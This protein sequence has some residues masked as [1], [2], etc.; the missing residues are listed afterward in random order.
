MIYGYARVSTIEQSTDVQ[1][2]ALQAAGCAEIIEE[3]GSGADRRRPRLAALLAKIQA[4]DIIVVWKIDRLARSVAHLS[5]IIELL[6]ERGAH[7]RS[8]TDPIDTSSPQGTFVTQL[9]GAVAEL[10]RSLIKERV[11]SGLAHARKQGRTGGNP[12]L[13]ARDPAALKELQVKANRR[14][15]AKY[16]ANTEDWIHIV[17]E[18]RPAKPWEVV[19][20]TVNANLVAGKEKWTLGRLKRAVAHMAKDNL[21]DKVLLTPAPPNKDDRL[22]TLVAG[23]KQANPT[24]TLGEIGGQLERMRERTSRGGLKWYPSSIRSLLQQAMKRGLLE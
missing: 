23:I 19:L 24:I 14:I 20:A 22:V 8:I 18:L 15:N 4:G 7:F 17:R 2:M 16:A 11:Q 12:K 13:K 10:E 5:E 1:A 3:K 21:V 6:R 9:L